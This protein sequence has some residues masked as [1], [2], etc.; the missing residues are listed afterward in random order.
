MKEQDIELIAEIAH[1][2]FDVIATFVVVAVIVIV[3]MI[4]LY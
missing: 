1:V 4:V 3:F 2:L